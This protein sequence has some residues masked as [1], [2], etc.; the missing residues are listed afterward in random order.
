MSIE[1]RSYNLLPYE[2]RDIPRRMK[3]VGLSSLAV[4]CWKF[5]LQA[6][7]CNYQFADINLFFEADLNPVEYRRQREVLVNG[8]GQKE[9]INMVIERLYSFNVLIDEF[10]LELLQRISIMSEVVL[11]NDSTTIEIKELDI[12]ELVKYPDFLRLVKVSFIAPSADLDLARTACCRLA[13]EGAPYIDG[14]DNSGGLIDIGGGTDCN[15]SLSY[16][17]SGMNLSVAVL[18]ASGPI[19]YN[20]QYQLVSGLWVDISGSSETITLSNFG[21]YRANV[22][23]GD[24]STS[25]EY[26]YLDPCNFTVELEFDGTALNAIVNGG[27]AVP[28]YTWTFKAI[29]SDPWSTLPTIYGTHVPEFS[30]YYKVQ[31]FCGVCESETVLEVTVPDCS[32]TIAL[33]RI[34]ESLKA[35]VLGCSGTP[36]YQWY[37]DS[38]SGYVLQPDTTDTIQLSGNGLY[39]VFVD[40]SGC[41][42][43]LEKLILDEP[44][45]NM[46]AFLSQSGN[47]LTVNVTDAPCGLPTVKWFLN[48]GTGEIPLIVG[49]LTITITQNGLYR[50]EVTCGDCVRN[51]TILVY[52]CNECN[53]NASIISD[54]GDPEILTVLITG[55]TGSASILWE[56]S[57]DGVMWVSYGTG[58]SI[59]VGSAGIYRVTV[60]CG[61]CE[62]KKGYF[63][64]ASMENCFFGGMPSNKAVCN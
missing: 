40:C 63:V 6:T 54:N 48:P 21:N 37:K 25:A 50:A 43:S 47:D 5:R 42:D 13:Y 20:W 12:E 9:V 27:C 44:E 18:G 45:C 41:T 15:L 39:K 1:S 10:H 36:T 55:C 26:E 62:V 56:Y 58:T 53:L 4:S 64:C 34:S 35:V 51:A 33:N 8:F 57:M 60:K 38:G 24:C 29:P 16:S 59:T 7:D 19:S 2:N 23:N 46:I 31:V 22:T 30:G 52:D 14:C 28:E 17:L 49:P 3:M 32:Y 11:T 61:D